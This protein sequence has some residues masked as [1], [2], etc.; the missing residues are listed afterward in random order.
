[1]RGVWRRGKDI[2]D[3]KVPNNPDMNDWHNES[4]EDMGI[5][6]NLANRGDC[7]YYYF[8]A[9]DLSNGDP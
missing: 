2:H 4:L 3:Y 7:K 6:W 1:M 5:Y 8:Q 9:V